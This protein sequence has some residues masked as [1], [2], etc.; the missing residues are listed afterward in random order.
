MVRKKKKAKHSL[1]TMF[2]LLIF[3]FSYEKFG[4]NEYLRRDKEKLEMHQRF[5]RAKT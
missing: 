2:L 4:R 5:S 3:D 1:H